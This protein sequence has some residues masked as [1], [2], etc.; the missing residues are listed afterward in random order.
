MG[1]YEETM[2]QL[3]EMKSRYDSGFSY[4]DKQLLESLNRL[5]FG[6]GI[7]NTGCND[8]YR[9]AYIIIMNHLK[10]IKTMP[11]KPNYILKAGALIHPAGTSKFYTNALP[12]D[13]IAEEHLSKF[14][15][16]I[17]K[18]AHYPADYEQRVE[19]YKARKQAEL[20]DSNKSSEGNSDDIEQPSLQDSPSS[21][22][23]LSAKDEEISG[24]KARLAEAEE[25]LALAKQ[26]QSETEDKLS[27]AEMEKKDLLQMVEELKSANTATD[28]E[29]FGEES[30]ETASLRMELETV[31]TELESANETIDKLKIDNRALKAANTRLKNNATKDSDI[32]KD[33]E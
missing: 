24:L 30:E 8:C 11:A 4:S 17:I 25:A 12:S 9:D 18:F 20:S 1:S 10:K 16:D 32:A 28:E 14:P 22:N 27:K 7:T 33:S 26:C 23:E 5:I 29:S 31:K 2:L 3:T 6:K 21:D 15:A 19:A 13:D